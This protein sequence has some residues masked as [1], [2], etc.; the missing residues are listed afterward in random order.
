MDFE[1]QRVYFLSVKIQF[2]SF[3]PEL[4]EQ[5]LD[6]VMIILSKSCYTLTALL[7]RLFD[8]I[9]LIFVLPDSIPAGDEIATLTRA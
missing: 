7:A 5:C 8:L 4:L 9:T 1:G 2:L 3:V 6:T